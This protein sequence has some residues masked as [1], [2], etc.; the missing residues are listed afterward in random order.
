MLENADN[1]SHY[2]LRYNSGLH[3][4]LNGQQ[5]SVLLNNLCKKHPG[6]FQKLYL[7]GHSMGGLVIRSACHYAERFGYSWVK[8]IKKIFLIGVPN[9]G[10]VLERVG[11]FSA[12]ILKIF[13]SPYMKLTSDLIH[14]RSAGI[15]DL[16]FGYLVDEDWQNK[17]IS[18]LSA[19]DKTEIHL[20]PN[21][22]YI[23]LTGSLMKNDKSKI[24][25]LLGDGMVHASSAE[26]V[27]NKRFRSKVQTVSITESSH[28]EL[29]H[30]MA[31]FEKF[32]ELI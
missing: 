19:K 1:F 15:Q 31:V 24:A 25:R 5:L 32:K 9:E 26:K 11:N 27:G 7:V 28:H 17:D 3:I 12:N 14:S 6:I 23:V 4:S 16:R 13:S 18:K 2:Y 22:Q 8:R 30:S 29:T 20:L 10:A 21:T